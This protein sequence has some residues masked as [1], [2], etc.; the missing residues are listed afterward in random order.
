MPVTKPTARNA[1]AITNWQAA[2]DS[3]YFFMNII[4]Q[5]LASG[6]NN[7]NRNPIKTSAHTKAQFKNA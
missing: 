5:S 4:N 6:R 7:K 2:K 1:M 3:M